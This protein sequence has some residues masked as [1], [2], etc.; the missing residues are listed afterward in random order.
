MADFLTLFIVHLHKICQDCCSHEG[1]GG[2]DI[3]ILCMFLMEKCQLET[4]N[5]QIKMQPVELLQK[6]EKIRE[7]QCY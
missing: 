1:G 7:Q 3:N 5:Y 6:L 4:C 2:D